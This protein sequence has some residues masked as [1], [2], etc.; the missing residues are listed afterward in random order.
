[1][2]T[3]QVI[4]I[5]GAH[6]VDLDAVCKDVA[7]LAADGDLVLVHGCSDATNRLQDLLGVAAQFVTSPS[8]YQSRFTTRET[9]EAMIQASAQVNSAIVQRLQRLGVRALGLS[10]LDGG[11]WR[12][13]RKDAIRS[14]ENGKV[15]VLRGGH[16]GKVT[17]VNH[18][19]LHTLRQAGYLPVL[20]LPAVSDEGIPINVDADR[21]AA[22]TA[23]ALGAS[24]LV[25]LSN[26]PGLLRDVDDPN[27][28][29]HEVRHGDLAGA[30]Q[31]A[32]G[33]MR[34]K[35]LAASE[36]LEGGVPR[37]ILGD[38]RCANPVTRALQGQGTCLTQ[39]VDTKVT[40]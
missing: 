10:G 2:K 38:A 13:P 22:A 35:M 40:I 12:G 15:R 27:S 18:E 8:G 4:K 31:W 6:G 32:Q 30:M 28:L 37:V 36:A 7:Q 17:Q 33:R 23:A 11:L 26:V 29:V 39:N 21:A 14:V 5:G 9:V 19:L 24:D 34:M 1:M 3:T 20:G 16:T 25:I